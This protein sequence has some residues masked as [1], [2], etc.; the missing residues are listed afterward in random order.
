MSTLFS[1]VDIPLS[2]R[3]LAPMPFDARSDPFVYIDRQ[4]KHL[5]RHIQQ[6]LDAQ[7]DGLLAGLTG[8]PDDEDV[9]SN[10]SSTP[11]I[12]AIG[13]SERPTRTIPVRQPPKKKI[14]LRAARRG[15][16][17]SMSDLLTLREEEKKVIQ[18]RINQRR[19]VITEV[20]AFSNK[21]RGLEKTISD[22]QNDRDDKTTREAKREAKD[23]ERE[24]EELELKLASMKARHRHLVQGI[25]EAENSA[26][27]K[28]SSY[29]ESLSILDSE[30]RKYLRNPPLQ[31]LKDDADKPSFYSLN[32]KRRTLEMARDHWQA[33]QSELRK[34]Q[35]GV[36]Q[37]IAALDE[38]GPIWQRV[39][40]EI[41]NFEKKLKEEMQQ[42]V[43]LSKSPPSGDQP[44]VDQERGRRI[45]ADM[46][47]TTRRLK[48]NLDIAEVKDWK[49]LVCSIGT[50]L[51]ALR[52]AKVMISSIFN[53]SEDTNEADGKESP[54]ED[55]KNDTNTSTITITNDNTNTTTLID[56]ASTSDD[57]H[58]DDPPADLLR[59]TTPNL[60]PTITRSEDEDDEPDPAWLLSDP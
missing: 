38:G 3:R 26:E 46:E 41:S 56:D 43:M 18:N 49:L 31:P 11:T 51:E 24:I 7:S 37:E 44:P 36:D 29:K 30:V 28:L 59:D 8:H 23:L 40:G 17:R 10:G 42:S 35:R 19:N 6:L 33:E 60:A 21:K 15:I 14:G 9:L 13:S 2:D 58:A 50:E 54:R 22:M 34:R 25:A 4:A 5:Q 55:N 32:P 39:L 47:A 1:H 27:A 20:D 12:S 48:E 53:L 16:L 45:L 57:E 52:E